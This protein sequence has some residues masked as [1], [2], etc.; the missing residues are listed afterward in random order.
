MQGCTRM[1]QQRQKIEIDGEHLNAASRQ[2]N[3]G[4]VP[5]QKCQG[6][7]RDLWTKVTLSINPDNICF[8]P[9]PHQ[10]EVLSL[11]YEK[12]KKKWVTMLV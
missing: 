7:C 3:N 5:D 10:Q 12:M 1:R 8:P 4:T 6:D 11:I 9:Q 2:M